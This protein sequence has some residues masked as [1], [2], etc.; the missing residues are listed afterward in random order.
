MQYIQDKERALLRDHDQILGMWAP[1][2]STPLNAKS[3]NLNPDT[4]E[5]DELTVEEVVTALRS[6]GLKSRETG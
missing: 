2:S 5:G 4:V 1:I 3:D 6:M